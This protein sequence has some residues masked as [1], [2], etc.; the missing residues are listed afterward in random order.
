M[1]Y[2]TNQGIDGANQAEMGGERVSSSGV[3]S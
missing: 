1:M 3:R 2:L